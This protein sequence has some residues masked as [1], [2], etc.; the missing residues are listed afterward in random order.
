MQVESALLFETPEQLCARVYRAVR[1]GH[2]IPPIRFEFRRFTRANSTIRLIRGA[3]VMRVTDLLKDAPAPI[4]EALAFILICK[5]FRQPVPAECVDR[6]RLYLN[7]VD[8]RSDIHL[9]RKTRGRKRF[10]APRGRYFDLTAIFARLN[11]HFF[12]GKLRVADLGWS[13]HLSRSI[14]G[15]FDS[16]HNAIVL[17]RLLDQPRVPALV[18]DYVMFH[19]MLHI[20]HPVETD[21]PRRSIHTRAFRHA[22]RAFPGFEEAKRI[23]RDTVLACSAFT[24]LLAVR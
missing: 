7:R 1:P 4:V 21:G 12:E 8:V 24:A 16:S 9:I 14:L 10:L 18:V 23:I 13:R 3:L 5:L 17:S 11:N 6:Y 22:E 15:H 2:D 19:E 20:A